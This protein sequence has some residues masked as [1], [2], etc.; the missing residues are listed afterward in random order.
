MMDVSA[1]TVIGLGYQGRR[2]LLNL[3][4]DFSMTMH[5]TIHLVVRIF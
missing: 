5:H 3:C 2:D 4:N 1:G